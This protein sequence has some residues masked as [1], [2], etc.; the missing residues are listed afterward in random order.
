MLVGRHRLEQLNLAL[1]ELH[2]L[3]IGPLDARAHQAHEP[4]VAKE[5]LLECG[6]FPSPDTL[7]VRVL[8]ADE[9]EQGIQGLVGVEQ[10]LLID[11]LCLL[12]R[13]GE[14][15]GPGHLAIGEAERPAHSHLAD[16]LLERLDQA[17]RCGR[18]LAIGP[19]G[20]LAP[21]LCPGIS[22]PGILDEP[23]F[24]FNAD[25]SLLRNGDDEVHLEFGLLLQPV[26]DEALGVEDVIAVRELFESIEHLSLSVLLGPLLWELLRVD[27]G[28]NIEPIQVKFIHA[29]SIARQS[30]GR[31][32]F[33]C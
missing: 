9:A 27:H 4:E 19:L 8:L 1:L 15:R 21:I 26:R 24:D 17:V 25:Q 12:D 14:T 11:D 22:G 30:I 29:F 31:N 3:L 2:E 18:R 13:R 6:V 28:L 5:T 7:T 20:Q 33:I 16:V 10:R 23:P 32:R